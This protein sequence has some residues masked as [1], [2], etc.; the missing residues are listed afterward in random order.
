MSDAIW[1][2][3]AL[4]GGILLGWIS[5]HETVAAECDR[6]NGFYVGTK[7]YECKRMEKKP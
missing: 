4:L 5:A 7:V 1:I 3:V 2:L 6:L